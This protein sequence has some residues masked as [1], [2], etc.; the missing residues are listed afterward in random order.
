HVNQIFYRLFG[1]VAV[2]GIGTATRFYFVSWLGERTVADVRIAVQNN[3]LRLSPRWFE[4]NRPAEIASRL[5]ADT[6]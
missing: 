4:E 6:A 5:T 3:L 1:L 2:L